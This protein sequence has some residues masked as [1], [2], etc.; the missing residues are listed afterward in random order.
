MSPDEKH[1]RRILGAFALGIFVAAV[2]SLLDFFFARMGIAPAT[3]ALND[4]IIGAAAGIFAYIWMCQQ[5]ARIALENSTQKFMEEIVQNE[6]K[7]IALEL[8][9]TVCQAQTGAVM[10]LEC[11]NDSLVENQEARNHVYRALHLVRES[12]TEMRCALWD[13]YPEELEKVHLKGAIEYLIKDLAAG[14][15]LNAHFLLEGTIRQLPP[16]IEKG[17]LRISQEALSN[18]VKHARA[19]EVQVELFLDSQR[20]RLSVKDDGQGFQPELRPGSFGLTSMENR[21]K[22]LGGVWTIH[23]EPG[24]G[25]E[26]HASIPI[27]SALN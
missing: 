12:M 27:P 17:L 14:N 18:V 13:L 15:G 20:A 3:T 6:R 4:L 16:E 22:A 1:G 25:T 21:T 23:S 11:A 10:H 7:R 24:R 19:H 26:V 2:N 9:D 5:S 8:H